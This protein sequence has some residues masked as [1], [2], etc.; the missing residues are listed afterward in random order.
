MGIVWRGRMRGSKG[1]EYLVG[2]NGEV[3]GDKWFVDVVEGLEFVKIDLVRSLTSKESENGRVTFRRCCKE[4]GGRLFW[5]I[6][7]AVFLESHEGL[8][9]RRKNGFANGR[10]V[11]GCEGVNVGDGQ[12]G[13]GK[14][15][16]YAQ[17]KSSASRGQLFDFLDPLRD[18]G[19]ES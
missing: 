15:L 4:R 8:E 1:F 17:K 18:V 10:V 3:I 19:K 12:I 7:N 9:I 11:A 5:Y 16:E 6:S 14:K 13:G 2:D